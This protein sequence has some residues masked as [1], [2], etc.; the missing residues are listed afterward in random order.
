MKLGKLDRH[1]QREKIDH[2]L[3]PHTKINSKWIKYLKAKT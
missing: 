3:S 1:M 2:C